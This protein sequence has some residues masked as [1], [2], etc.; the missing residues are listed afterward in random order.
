MK[1]HPLLLQLSRDHHAALK[2]AKRIAQV[3]ADG[4]CRALTAT[5]AAMFRNDLERHFELEEALL[6]PCLERLEATE[7]ARRLLQEHSHLRTL[8]AGIEG[9][10]AVELKSFGAALHDHVRYEE[11]ELFPLVEPHLSPSR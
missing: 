3:S 2:L 7:S 8:A 9:G 5:V 1:R 11:R 10:H 4:D 6:L